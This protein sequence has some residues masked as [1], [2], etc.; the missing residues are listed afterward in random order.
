MLV[1][2]APFLLLAADSN[3]PDVRQCQAIRPGSKTTVLNLGDYD[4]SLENDGAY[5]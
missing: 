1:C 2:L 4:V 3:G 5:N